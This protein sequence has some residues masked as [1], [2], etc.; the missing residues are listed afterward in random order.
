MCPKHH[1]MNGE[2]GRVHCVVLK[3]FSTATTTSS[4]STTVTAVPV[5]LSFFIYSMKDLPMI[6]PDYCATTFAFH[7]CHLFLSHM[8]YLSWKKRLVSLPQ[9]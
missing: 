2:G 6:A 1:V 4:T 5:C 7:Y 8:G 9:L 3:P